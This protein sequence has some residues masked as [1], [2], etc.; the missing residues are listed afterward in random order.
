[1]EIILYISTLAVSVS[2]IFL[3]ALKKTSEQGDKL[4]YIFEQK[5]IENSGTV[6]STAAGKENIIKEEIVS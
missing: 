6:E 4:D 5:I 2:T 3:M 1:M